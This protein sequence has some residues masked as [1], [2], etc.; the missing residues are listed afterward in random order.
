MGYFRSTYKLPNPLHLSSGL[1]EEHIWSFQITALMNDWK[2]GQ[3]LEL[4][5]AKSCNSSP[6]CK[7]NDEK[8]QS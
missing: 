6:V 3:K 7:M 1:Q 4:L 5:A 8:G 2:G